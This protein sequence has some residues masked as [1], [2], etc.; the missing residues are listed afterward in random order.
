MSEFENRCASCKHWER[1]MIS[2]DF[3]NPDVEG[4]V[5]ECSLL[6]DRNNNTF[7]YYYCEDD[8]QELT[9]SEM[10]S[11]QNLFTHELFGCI[12]YSKKQ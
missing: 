5:G 10:I 6:C 12:H 3:P 7:Q 2:S 8:A 9:K 4:N 1:S 11:C